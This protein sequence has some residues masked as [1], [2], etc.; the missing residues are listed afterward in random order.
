MDHATHWSVD[1]LAASNLLAQLKLDASDELTDLITRHFAAHRRSLVSWAAERTQSTIIEAM[2]AAAPTL[3]AHRDEA[4]IRGFNQAEEIIA[5]LQPKALLDL[6]PGVPRSK[7][8]YLRSMIRQ[9]R[10]P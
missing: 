9:S 3:F 1:Q 6:D 10:Q 7:G 8:Q 4:W 2:E 5:T